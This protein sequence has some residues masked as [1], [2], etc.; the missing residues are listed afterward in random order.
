M[1]ILKQKEYVNDT[2]RPRYPKPLFIGA[3]AFMKVATR[4]DAFLIYILP[5]PN[6][7]P[8]PHEIPP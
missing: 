7:E 1:Q 3:K 8:C 2:R 5:S 6:V 4:G